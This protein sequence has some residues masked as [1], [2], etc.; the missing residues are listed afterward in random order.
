MNAKIKATIT[1]Q[2][3]QCVTK[4]ITHANE[5]LDTK[6]VDQALR[7][8]QVCQQALAL[9]ELLSCVPTTID[10]LIDE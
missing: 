8:L 5:A 9:L 7:A 4:S 2:L 10:P 6:G 3:T 1:N